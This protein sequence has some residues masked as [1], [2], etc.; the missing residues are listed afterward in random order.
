[1]DD[2]VI[3]AKWHQ[4]TMMAVVYFGSFMANL[5]GTIVN[6][7]LPTIAGE[8]NISP[9]LASLIILAYLLSEAG[10]LLAFGKLGDLY[11]ARPVFLAGF[12]LF[13]LSSLACGFSSSLWNLVAMRAVQGIGGAMLYSI[14]L[15]FASLYMPAEKR[16]VAM[17]CSTLAAA[18]GVA[19]GPTAGGFIAHYVGWRCIFFINVPLGIVALLLGYFVLPGNHP[20]AKDRRF[21]VLGAFYQTAF[22][23]SLIFALN[24]GV[25]LGWTS[26]PILSAF[27]ASLL[28][29]FLFVERER[30]IDYPILDLRLFTSRN[31]LFYNMNLCLSMMLLGGMLFLIPFYLQDI[32]NLKPGNIG[33]IMS[34]ISLGQFL[35]PYAG[36]LG[37]RKGHRKVM[38]AGLSLG[39]LSFGMFVATDFGG[40]LWWVIAAIVLFGL[41]QGLNRPP[42]IQLI[43]ASLPSERKGTASCVTALMRSLGLVLGVVLFETTLS[44]FLPPSVSLN[45]VSLKNSGISTR[46]LHEAFITTFIEGLAIS[47]LMVILV[48]SVRKSPETG[49]G[50]K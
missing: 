30:R 26:L 20:P 27:G 1:M 14:M 15:T 49:M 34:V 46:L 22:L 19:V 7:C 41:S 2:Y 44:T 36:R 37:D 31:T 3:K 48:N 45:A 10:P 28:M 32:V 13:A 42:N 16:G 50:S 5:D 39:I 38:L 6:V 35:G 9:S 24:Q 8:M 18:L 21:D 43:M 12:A 47:I 4:W 40:P 25:E 29:A 23:V 17:G 33:L 11:G